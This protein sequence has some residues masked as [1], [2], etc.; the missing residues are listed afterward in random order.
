M[1]IFLIKQKL[2]IIINSKEIQKEFKINIENYKKVSEK[3]K[4][5]EKNGKGQEFYLCKF[6][7]Y[8]FILW[9][10]KSN[11]IINIYSQFIFFIIY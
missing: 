5:G 2:K 4:I 8:S 9:N 1:Q 6:Y 10:V 11:Y 7:F 3:Y